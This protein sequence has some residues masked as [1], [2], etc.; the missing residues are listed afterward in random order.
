MSK[1]PKQ[2]EVEGYLAHAMRSLGLDMNSP[3]LKDSPKRVAK[4][5]VQEIFRGLFVAPPIITTFPNKGC[6]ELVLV[7][8]LTLRST[9]A[10]HFCPFTGQAWI[11]YIP[12]RKLAGLSKFARM[13][14][15]VAARPQTQELLGIQLA[16]ELE[17]RLKPQA[18]GVVIRAHH[19]CMSCRGVKE[20]NEAAMVTSVMRGKFR[21]QPETRAEFLALLK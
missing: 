9:C 18:L 20:S 5:W 17:S 1:Q 21:R 15:W 14:D 6:D 4:M 11:G 19:T 12:G 10:H 2:Y 8:P 13:L 3:H 7:G 16:D